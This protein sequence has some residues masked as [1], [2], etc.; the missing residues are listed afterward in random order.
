M[1]ANI[2]LSADF[3]RHNTD[4]W[5]SDGRPWLDALPQIVAQCAEQWGL[6]R[7]EPAG[8]LSYNWLAAAE[9]Y[10]G[11][12]VVLKIVPPEHEY[13]QEEAALRLYAGDGAARLVASDS[14]RRALL[15]ER[16]EP[17]TML[18]TLDDDVAATSVAVGV[19]Q[20]LWRPVPPGSPIPT[21]EA[22][23]R[24][25]W[26]VRER[27]GGGTGPLPEDVVDRGRAAYRDLL[28]SSGEQVLLHGDLH[29]YNILSAEREPWL[30]ID[31]KGLVGEREYEPFAC[32]RNP[33]HVMREST[34]RKAVMARRLDQLAEELGLDRE[35]MRLWAF[36]QAVLSAVWEMDDPHG[37]WEFDLAVAREL[38]EL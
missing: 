14:G 11:E 20:A 27:H 18:S 31:P 8:D 9:R 24:E 5:L 30:A 26:E 7:L 38:E 23:A 36:A 19:M 10:S 12:R 32:L 22:W 3:I 35:R 1:V 16:L 29:H 15:L 4:Q 2:P 34:N 28:A 33:I 37:G 21:V 25:L 13:E 17:G 6:T